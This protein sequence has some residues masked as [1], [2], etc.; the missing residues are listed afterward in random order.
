M[1]ESDA[2]PEKAVKPA[3]VGKLLLVKLVGE[4]WNK[5]NGGDGC[6][7]VHHCDP[8]CYYAKLLNVN[9]ETLLQTNS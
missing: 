9:V 4:P 8:N 7:C 2:G 6:T 5:G 1:S 3:T